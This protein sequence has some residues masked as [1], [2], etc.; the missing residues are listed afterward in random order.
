MWDLDTI[1]HINAEAASQSREAG[2]IPHRLEVGA[3]IDSWPPFPFPHLG[4]ACADVDANHRRI[5]TLFVDSSGF[6]AEGEPALTVSAFQER[7]HALFSEHGP[8][9][10]AIEDV[11]QF[12]VY[13]A[14]WG[15]DN[16]S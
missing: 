4:D 12:Q 10:L 16:G 3:D 15:A 1:R 14:V 6:G 11:G 9:L 5:E 8:L 7:L 2:K 13:V